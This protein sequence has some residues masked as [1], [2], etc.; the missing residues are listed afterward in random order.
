M[1]KTFDH[2]ATCPFCGREQTITVP[3]Q[4]YMNWQMGA[5]VQNAFRSLTA[6]EREMF[7][8]GMCDDCWP[9][10]STDEDCMI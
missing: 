8:T 6:S 3:I 5:L 7:I 1:T 10:D 2:E 4:E 9:K